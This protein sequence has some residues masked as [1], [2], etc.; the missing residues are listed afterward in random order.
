MRYKKESLWKIPRHEHA[1]LL[2]VI[3]NKS[4]F[5]G[6]AYCISIWN[7]YKVTG[8]RLCPVCPDS[9]DQIRIHLIPYLI[10]QDNENKDP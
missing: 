9:F 2:D 8:D 10:D 7:K 6:L 4:R 1:A 3:R 5:E